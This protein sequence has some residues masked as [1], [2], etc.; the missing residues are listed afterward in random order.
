MTYSILQSIPSVSFKNQFNWNYPICH[1]NFQTISFQNRT[2]FFEVTTST[3]PKWRGNSLLRMSRSP[4]HCRSQ[5]LNWQ[6]PWLS[7]ST[8]IA[9]W[10]PQATKQSATKTFSKGETLTCHTWMDQAN[11]CFWY[12]P[13]V[14]AKLKLIAAV[15]DGL[16]CSVTKFDILGTYEPCEHSCIL[17]LIMQCLWV[18]GAR[19]L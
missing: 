15:L 1:F 16:L 2:S 14:V 18:F 12:H 11:E 10:S 8:E 5:K 6:H 13:S 4:E 3:S 19:W 7:P 9:L 17:I